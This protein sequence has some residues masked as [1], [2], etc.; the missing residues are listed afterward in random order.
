MVVMR[1]SL[2]PKEKFTGKY[3]LV[4]FLDR[5]EHYLQEPVVYIDVPI[6]KGQVHA[7]CLRDSLYY[8]VLGNIRGAQSLDTLSMIDKT[9]HSIRCAHIKIM[10]PKKSKGRRGRRHQTT[11]S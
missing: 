9:G 3:R 8:V 10:A 7:H 11:V 4:L 2:V 5:T 6:C 1:Q